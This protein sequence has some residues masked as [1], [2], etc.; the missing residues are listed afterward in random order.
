L[1]E[2]M[3]GKPYTVHV[4]VDPVFGERLRELPVGEPVWIAETKINR[5]AYEAVG[6]ERKPES[7]VVGLSSFKVDQAQVPDDWL[8]SELA[9][10][11]LHHG[12]Y[13]HDPPWSRINVI[14]AKWTERIQR[15]LECFGFTAHLDTR[16]GFEATKELANNV[17][18]GTAG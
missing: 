6:R 18:E 1:V 13:S 5:A 17:I 12:A 10:I 11:D 8:I 4:I 15:E 2:K 9:T 14:G 3:K 16:E 7:Y